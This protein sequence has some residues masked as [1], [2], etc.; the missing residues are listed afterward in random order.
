MTLLF[1]VLSC[2]KIERIVKVSTGITNIQNSKVKVTGTLVDV[3]LN[4]IDQYGH[5]WST[6]SNPTIADSKSDLGNAGQPLNFESELFN[7]NSGQKYYVRAYATS[8][9]ETTYGEVI[10][11]SIDLNALAVD[12]GNPDY[13][14]IQK[15]EIQGSVSNIGSIGIINHGHCWSLTPNPTINDQKSDLGQLN[16]DGSFI[17]DMLDLFPDKDY[18]VRTYIKLTDGLVLYSNEVTIKIPVL[19]VVSGTYSKPSSSTVIFEG[20]IL[21]PG[22][23][24][25]I[26]HGHCWS[27]SNS[28]PNLNDE[29]ISLGQTNKIGKFYST[30]NNIINGETY[31]YRAYGIYQN[32]VVYGEIK[33]FQ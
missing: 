29:T 9:S 20:E 1:C 22:I 18:Y 4:G 19:K 5:C 17:S 23:E 24:P 25:I 2:K 3:G 10:S 8:N 16:T 33:T 14:N 11:F 27:I 6:Q 30:L 21:E 26:D 32:K 13:I 7:L 12:I 15:V 28:N 31:Y